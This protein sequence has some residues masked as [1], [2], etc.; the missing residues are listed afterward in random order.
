MNE[1]K[2]G[3]KIVS[4]IDRK[5]YSVCVPKGNKLHTEYKIEEYVY[6]KDERLPLTFFKHRYETRL[7]INNYHMGLYLGKTIRVFICE[8]VLSNVE[9]KYGIPIYELNSVCKKVDNITS[10]INNMKPF[11][12]DS[13][14]YY[15]QYAVRNDKYNINHRVFNMWPDGTGFAKGIKLVREIE[16]YR[17]FL[18]MEN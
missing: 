4:Y 17:D 14:N 18:K 5:Y 6:T 1:I 2:T 11:P 9:P 3:Y 8:F 12:I 16:D 10:Y 13:D 7:F 15:Q